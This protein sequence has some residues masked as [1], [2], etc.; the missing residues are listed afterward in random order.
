MTDISR[1]IQTISIIALPLLF[2]ITFHEMAHGFIADRLGDPTARQAGR[3]TLNPLAH[4][5]PFG[6]V[7]LP[8]ILMIPMLLGYPSMLF[9][10]AKPVP[11]NYLNLRHPKQDMTWV[12]AAGPGMNLLL[13]L[14]SSVIFR[15][16]MMIDPS[17]LFHVSR[18]GG[19]LSGG[20]LTSSILLPLALMAV[21][22]VNINI[23]LMIFNLIP[24]PPLD[25]GRVLVG[26]L[27]EQQAIAVSRIEP[28]G[29]LIIIALL[30]FDPQIG[31]MRA[32]IWPFVTIMSNLILGAPI[33]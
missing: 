23:L 4:I 20:D 30:M 3:L 13:A 9:G 25:G 24:I 28:Y 5:D 11:V 26:V 1:L 12:A 19:S 18:F 32:I 14:I 2:A 10:Y 21:Y 33:L 15:L 16:L 7:I 22:S 27:P 17:L 8:L 6:T 31:I 29:M